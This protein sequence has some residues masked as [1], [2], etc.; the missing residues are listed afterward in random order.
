M[1][2][3]IFILIV[4]A[5]F[6]IGAILLKKVVSPEGDVV[7]VSGAVKSGKSLYCVG[8]SLRTLYSRRFYV[9]MFNWCFRFLFYP[10]YCW[11]FKFKLKGSLDYPLLYS[12]IPIKC[13]FY[14]PLTRA[15]LERESIIIYK[16]V[17][18][19]DEASLVA[20]SMSYNDKVL[21]EQLCLFIKLFGHMSHGGKLYINSQDLKDVHFGIKRSISNIT[22][23]D[24]RIKL[25]F[26]TI[27]KY[28]RFVS[29][30]DDNINT[31]SDDFYFDI[32]FNFTYK[33]YDCYCYS[34]LTD[35]KPIVNNNSL[36]KDLKRNN[37]LSFKKW[38]TI[39]NDFI[40]NDKK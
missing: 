39:S 37:I 29:M 25:P 18:L 12:N 20:D 26:I 27:F 14:V 8:K 6:I 35:F 40:E 13:R 38:I 36:V 11:F 10:F 19:L 30:I 21:N 1:G 7:F 23:I 3:F 31:M 34:I 17:C 24:R 4:I 2:D 15:I 33:K 16:S 5:C 32:V 28:K 22:Y 9:F